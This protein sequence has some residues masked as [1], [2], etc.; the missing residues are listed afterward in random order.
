MER[1]RVLV[2]DDHTVFRFGVKALLESVGGFEVVGEATTGEEAVRLTRELRPDAVLMD[3]SMPGE[4]GVEATRRISAEDPTVGVVVVT[5]LEDDDSVFAAMRAGARG[6][7][8]KNSEAGEIVRIVRAVAEGDA[9]FGPEIAKRLLGFFSAPRVV[10]SAAF[11]ELTDREVEVLDLIA[12]GET[13]ANIARRLYVSPKTVRNHITNVFSKLGIAD[14][15][16][17]VVRARQA[18]LG[19]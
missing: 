18:G 9:Q 1:V 14:R 11:P 3:L 4:G 7:V 15:A 5:M 12:R 6:Y 10:R 2:A 17:A 8:L 19:L 13:N 16:K